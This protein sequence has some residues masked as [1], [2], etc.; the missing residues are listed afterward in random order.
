MCCRGEKSC[1]CSC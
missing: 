1:V